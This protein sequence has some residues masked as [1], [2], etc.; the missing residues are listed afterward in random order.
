M[1]RRIAILGVLGRMK[2]SHLR[3]A[4]SQLKPVVFWSLLI[5]SSFTGC[6]FAHIGNYKIER[7]NGGLVILPPPYWEHSES[8]KITI[9]F[10]IPA[11]SDHHQNEKCSTLVG[12]FNLSL[13]EGSSSEWVGTLPSLQTWQESMAGGSFSQEFER[14]LGQISG[15]AD[16]GCLALDRA[17]MLTEAVRESI[18]IRVEETDYYRYGYRLGTGSIDLEPG[19]RLKIERAEFDP[20]GKFQDTSTVYYR[21]ARDS[22]HTIHFQIENAPPQ[23]SSGA[24]LPDRTLAMRESG[25]YYDRLFFLGKHVPPNLHYAA[26]VVGTR[27]RSRLEEIARTIRARPD[28]GCAAAT[29]KEITCV[30]FEG[31]VSVSAEIEVSLNGSRFFLEPRDTIRDLLSQTDNTPCRSNPRSLRIE[32][33]FLKKLTPVDFDSVGDSILDLVLVGGDRITCSGG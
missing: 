20:L 5:V 22:R 13:K 9:N 27:S 4:R 33:E 24:S 28:I 12:E 29:E 2:F 7:M 17:A 1:S 10:S 15:L 23:E 26:M 8:K 30:P 21:I 18:P 11:A 32:R 16:G 6:H 25:K 19:I 14:F 3:A 31:P